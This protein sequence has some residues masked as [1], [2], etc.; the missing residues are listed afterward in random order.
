M[1]KYR[2]SSFKHLDS[3]NKEIFSSLINEVRDMKDIYV[4]DQDGLRINSLTGSLVK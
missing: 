1:N 2:L 3:E 4:I